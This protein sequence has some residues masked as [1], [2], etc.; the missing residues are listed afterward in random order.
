M[1]DTFEQMDYLELEVGAFTVLENST[2]LSRALN[3]RH[4]FGGK[5]AEI[6]VMQNVLAR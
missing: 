4:L 6:G 3:I 2:R 1:E 5:K